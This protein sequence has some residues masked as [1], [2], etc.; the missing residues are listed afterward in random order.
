MSYHSL[1]EQI[2]YE[3]FIYFSFITAAINVHCFQ[4][5][6]DV[7]RIRLAVGKF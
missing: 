6:L 7:K 2:R 1:P 3:T 4:T 5:Q